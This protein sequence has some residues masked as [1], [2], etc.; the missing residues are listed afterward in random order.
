MCLLWF[1][2]CIQ[3]HLPPNP[4]NRGAFIRGI[5]QISIAQTFR[6]GFIEIENVQMAGRLRPFVGATILF[7]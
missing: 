1:I 4:P 2:F 3:P 6:F 7:N 5:V